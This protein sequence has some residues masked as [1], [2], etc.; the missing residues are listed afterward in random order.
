[1]MEHPVRVFTK[2]QLYESIGS[3]YCESDDKTMMVHISNLREKIEGDSKSPRYIQTVR[4]LGYKIEY[5]P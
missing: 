1:M 4:G 2:S 3:G 5:I